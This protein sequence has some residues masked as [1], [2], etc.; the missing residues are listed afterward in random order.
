[1]GIIS[2][3]IGGLMANRRFNQFQYSLEFN[4]VHLFM[5]VAIGST[6]APTL[7]AANS[8]GIASISRSGVGKYLITL[9]DAYNKFLSIDSV[10]NN[11]AGISVSA[12][13][14]ILTT[15]TN[16][17]TSTGGTLVVQFSAAGVAAE[18]ASGDTLYMHICLGN[19]SI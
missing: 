19:S 11:A 17:S 2:L 16:V 4:V 14:G 15:G 10:V 1:M 6:G 12:D 18:M 9:S 13:L 5:K 8:K 3:E 7:S